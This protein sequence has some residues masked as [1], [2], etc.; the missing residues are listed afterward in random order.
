MALDDRVSAHWWRAPETPPLTPPAGL[1]HLVHLALDAQREE[2]TPLTRSLDW[3][4]TPWHVKV[5]LVLC[6]GEARA[7]IARPRGVQ[8]VKPTASRS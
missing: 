5:P 4:R 8:L 3:L 7:I 1:R 6:Q 2:Q